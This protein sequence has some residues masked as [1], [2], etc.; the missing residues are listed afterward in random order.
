MADEMTDQ[1]P[2]GWFLK[3]QKM[4]EAQA[5]PYLMKLLSLHRKEARDTYRAHKNLPYDEIIQTQEPPPEGE[6]TRIDMEPDEAYF[7][8]ETG[9][10]QYR[11]QGTNKENQ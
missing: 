8:P 3:I 11:P 5:V 7:D 1:A 2:Q 4:T 6:M 9:T 10:I